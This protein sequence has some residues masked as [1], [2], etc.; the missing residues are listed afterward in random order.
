MKCRSL[1]VI[2]VALVFADSMVVK[3]QLKYSPRVVKEENTL[4]I[5]R[6]Q[7]FTM[8]LWMANNGV[9]GC[10][11]F[12]N[13]GSP[14]L[15]YP[16]GSGIQHLYAA[17]PMIGAIVEGR[18]KVSRAYRSLDGGGDFTGV[19]SFFSSDVNAIGGRRNYDDD[20]D[21]KIDEDELDGIDNDGDG[22]ID[23]DY[24][25][26]SEHDLYCGYTD[27]SRRYP[28]QNNVPLGIKVWQRSFAW[29]ERIK[30]PILPIEYNF[31]NIG[32]KV[33]KDVYLGFF[34]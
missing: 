17:G 25:A 1:I 3:C 32:R 6:Q 30:E 14:N 2:S 13:D 22:K 12:R 11:D 29:G 19:D 24:G 27:T 16:V 8:K 5:C 4:P 28:V 15:E 9:L 21:G 23:E 31:V 18:R 33:L 7:G 20:H 10:N 34:A 26:V